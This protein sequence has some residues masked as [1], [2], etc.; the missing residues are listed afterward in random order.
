MA[1]ERLG[2]GRRQFGVRRVDRLGTGVL[3][4]DAMGGG[5]RGV[6][7]AISGATPCT[8]RKVTRSELFASGYTGNFCES[9]QA[10]IACMWRGRSLFISP[11]RASP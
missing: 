11:P 9:F 7:D 2:L 1:V 4:D 6:A 10:I 8:L 5:E 3:L